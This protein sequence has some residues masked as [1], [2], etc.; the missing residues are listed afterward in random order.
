MRIDVDTVPEDIMTQCG[1]YVEERKVGNKTTK[2]V[3][4]YEK[5]IYNGLDMGTKNIVL[6]RRDESN[7]VKFK[8]EVNGFVI[9]DGADGFSKQ[10][11][12]SNGVPF[13]PR[14]NSDGNEELV[15]LGE[16]AEN[17]AYAFGKVLQRPMSSGVLSATEK[18]AMK[19]MATIAHGIVGKLKDNTTLYYCVPGEALNS[20]VNVEFHQKIVQMIFDQLSKGTHSFQAHPINEARALVLSGF[21]DKTGIGISFGAGMVN[22]SYC[23]YGIPIYQFS[24][25]GSG[26]WIDQESGRATGELDKE[27][28]KPTVHVTKI[29]ESMAL[30]TEPPNDNLGRAIWINYRILIERVAKGIIDGFKKNE[31][32]ARAP[33]PMPIVIAGGTS[34]PE[35][36]IDLFKSVFNEQSMPFEISEVKRADDPLNAVAKGCLIAAE[37]HDVSGE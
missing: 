6:A 17:F 24:L 36:F 15:A 34:S 27:T 32:K 25:V 37:M 7:D 20:S 30:G 26:D 10:L 33:K 9:M 29:K 22:V 2:V 5:V 13:I 19:I 16:K 1:L 21:E 18:D 28:G 12:V 14:V 31:G 4:S 35:G 11:L 8:R 23:L 3:R